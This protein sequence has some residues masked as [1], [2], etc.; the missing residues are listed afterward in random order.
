[1]AKPE[2]VSKWV[3]A[4]KSWIGAHRTAAFLI[5]LAGIAVVALIVWA[6]WPKRGLPSYIVVGNGR[7]EA[8][9]YDVATKLT[10]RLADLAPHEG[11]MVQAG[12][13]VGRIAAREENAEWASS[14]SQAQSST[15]A[16]RR[17]QDNLRSAES[18]YSLAQVTLKRTQYLRTLHA[19]TGDKLD[20]DTS[21]MR[22]AEANLSAA[23][24]QV[25][26]AR[27]DVAAARSTA[28]RAGSHASEAF[29]LAPVTGPVLYRV[30]EPGTML[31]AGSK[32]LTVL[33]M[34]DMYMT[35]FLPTEQAGKLSVGD[36]ARVVL[37]ALT[38][39][40]MPARVR[41]VSPRNQFTP[42]EVETRRERDKLMFRVKVYVDRD[43]LAAHP[44]ALKAGMP[45]LT[46]LRLDSSKPWPAKLNPS[47]ASR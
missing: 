22:Q 35:V 1:M 34:N 9:E 7:I 42:R 8:T 19:S 36:E 14:K 46:Y 16:L 31:S 17:A 21:S 45:G 30:V 47:S 4:R 2:K 40:V 38:H 5:G 13:V 20:R 43:W 27:S 33:D 3:G 41:F 32:V 15:D 6:V 28:E 12:A 29:L 44:G 37:D 18:Q 11:D 23:R 26:G 39:Q 24:A 10:G 25:Q